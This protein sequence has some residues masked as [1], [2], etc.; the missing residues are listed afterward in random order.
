MLLGFCGKN[1]EAAQ[2]LLREAELDSGPRGERLRRLAETIIA[3]FLRLKV[4]PPDRSF[5]EIHSPLGSIGRA[6]SR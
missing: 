6:A 5:S 1:L 4:A 2:F 3:S